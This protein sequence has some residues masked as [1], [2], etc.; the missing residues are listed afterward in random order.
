MKSSRKKSELKDEIK[1]I[2]MSHEQAEQIKKNAKKQKMSFSNY[3][4]TKAVS[5]ENGLT[6]EI[7]V[8][9]QNIVNTACVT[10][11][12]YEPNKLESFRKKANSLWKKLS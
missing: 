4:V 10:I 11:Q 7:M 3:M 1:S 12:Q 6:P 9:F 2:R 8:E 5:E